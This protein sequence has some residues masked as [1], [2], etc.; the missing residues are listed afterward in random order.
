M[1]LKRVKNGY[2]SYMLGYVRFYKFRILINKGY[3][4]Y[5]SSRLWG[6]AIEDTQ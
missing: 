4:I 2:R 5:E 1:V 3:L 6:F